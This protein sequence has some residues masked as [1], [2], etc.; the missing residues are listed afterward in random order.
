MTTSSRRRLDASKD[1]SQIVLKCLQLARIDRPDILWSANQL[2]RGDTKWT[3]A[4]DKRLGQMSCH[5]GN[6]AEECRLGFIQDSSFQVFCSIV[7][8]VGSLSVHD[9]RDDRHG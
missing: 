3:R 9:P 6:T 7:A 2:A 5:V 8:P 4:N 1:C